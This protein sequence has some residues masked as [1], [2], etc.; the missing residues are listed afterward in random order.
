MICAGRWV[1][2]FLSL[3]C[4]QLV[5]TTPPHQNNTPACSSNEEPAAVAPDAPRPS[6]EEL[7]QEVLDVARRFVAHNIQLLVV[8]TEDRFLGQG[9][10]T[11]P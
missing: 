8:D 5:H 6:P 4:W 7:K 9:E 2:C 10:T 3:V 11:A 1:P